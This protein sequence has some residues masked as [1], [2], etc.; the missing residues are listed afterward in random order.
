[1]EASLLFCHI[2]CPKRASVS[3]LFPIFVARNVSNIIMEAT[4]FNPIQ[5]HLLKMFAHMNSEQE[6]REVQQ[7]LSAYYSKKVE[8]HANELWDK[9][10]LTQEKLDEMANMHERLP[11]R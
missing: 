2:F 3:D 1:M 5:L 8:E 9:L 10:D 4:V 6:L 7:V 11:Y